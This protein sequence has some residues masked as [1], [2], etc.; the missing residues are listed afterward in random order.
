MQTAAAITS[1]SLFLSG[2]ALGQASGAK[3]A[4]EVASVRRSTEKGTNGMMRGGPGS[5]DPARITYRNMPLRIALMQAYGLD[6]SD[7]LEAPDW[8]DTERYDIAANVPPGTTDEQCRQMLQGL[9]EKRFRLVVRHEIRQSQAYRLELAKGGPKFKPSNPGNPAPIP[10]GYPQPGPR[11]IGVGGGHEYL[12]TVR[13]AGI[14][15]LIQMLEAQ[16]HASLDDQTGLDGKYD[17]NLGFTPARYLGEDQD[18]KLPDVRVAVEG[19][20]GLR[21]AETKLPVEFVIIEK[22]SKEP[23]DN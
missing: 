10:S 12:L 4:F 5:D 19:Q 1:I 20:L 3:P 18:P 15:F 9:L 16:L 14:S 6:L 11:G 21:L 23:L 8:I 13:S 17:F 22:G 7:Q 2:L